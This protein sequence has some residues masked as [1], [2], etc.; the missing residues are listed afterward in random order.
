MPDGSPPLAVVGTTGDWFRITGLSEPTA[1]TAGLRPSA[2]H[3]CLLG[4]CPIGPGVGGVGDGRREPAG[5]RLGL[6]A[7]AATGRWVGRCRRWSRSA[8]RRRGAIAVVVALSRCRRRR[9]GPD[10]WSGGDT[11]APYRGPTKASRRRWPAASST[12]SST[13]ALSPEEIIDLLREAARGRLSW[14]VGVYVGRSPRGPCRSTV[15]PSGVGV[16]LR[17]SCSRGTPHRSPPG[18]PRPQATVARGSFGRSP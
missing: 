13:V 2:I 4:P 18:D 1:G 15:N 10:R 17:A 8:A 7:L 3:C 14:P 9:F 6:C 12:R 11:R 16:S 5:K